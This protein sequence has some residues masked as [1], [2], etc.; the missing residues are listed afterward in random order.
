MLADEINRATP[1]TQS[2]LLEAMEERQITVDGVT[3]RLE[4][5]F[6]VMATQ[7]PLESY[8]TFPLPDAQI[9]RFFMRLSLGYMTREQEMS[10][11][12]RVSTTDIIRGLERRVSDEETAYVRSAYTEVKVPR[13]VLEYMMD[14]VEAT[15]TA[16]SFIN[17]VSTRGAIALYKA[18]QVTAA[19]NGRDYVIPEDVKY[20]APHVLVHRLSAGS[21]KG[22]A[23]AGFLEDVLK[24]VRVPLE[25]V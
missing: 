20:V 22:G 9:D 1:R 17:G 25:T 15:R 10:V 7:N 23:A 21:S 8:G 12:S 19:L 24:K 3:T 13:E 6:M 5:P 2:S 18:A 14:I 4:E 16:S 11:L